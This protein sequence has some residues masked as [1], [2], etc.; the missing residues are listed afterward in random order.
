MK[1]T[2]R[3]LQISINIARRYARVTH[4]V[5]FPLAKRPPAEP[6]LC[7]AAPVGIDV[8]HRYGKSGAYAAAHGS[9]IHSAITVAPPPPPPWVLVDGGMMSQTT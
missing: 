1:M 4:K 6:Q 2:S 5:V 8:A 3:I 7:Q 9:I